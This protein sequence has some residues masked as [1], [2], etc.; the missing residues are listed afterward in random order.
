MRHV[1][2]LLSVAALLVPAPLLATGRGRCLPCV[3]SGFCDTSGSEE[4]CGPSAARCV[5]AS[6][7]LAFIS[8]SLPTRVHWAIIAP[9]RART[10]P[11][12]LR[13]R[14]RVFVEEAV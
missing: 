12:Q 7:I 1:A 8:T 6:G 4:P 13:G 5:P 11:G 10:K 3:F 2:C 14:L 9:R